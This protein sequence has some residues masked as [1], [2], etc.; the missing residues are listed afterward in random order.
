MESD[1]ESI[2]SDIF[3]AGRLIRENTAGHGKIDSPSMGHLKILSIV[4]EKASLTM[5]EVADCLYITPP[6]ATAI[7]DCMVKEGILERVL[8]ENDRRIV[9]LKITSKGKKIFK[10]HK[11]KIFTGMSNVFGILNKKERAEFSYILKKIIKSYKR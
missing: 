3:T 7:V 5:K 1:L 6:S 9:R 2:I 10:E 11:K 8:D 4:S